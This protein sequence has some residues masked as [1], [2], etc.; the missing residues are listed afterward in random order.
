MHSNQAVSSVGDG[1]PEKSQTC[2]SHTHT[3]SKE[4]R[5][6]GL[7]HGLRGCRKKG[8]KSGGGKKRSCASWRPKGELHEIT[9]A[10]REATAQG[11]GTKSIQCGNVSHFLGH[12]CRGPAWRASLPPGAATTPGHS[13]C[14]KPLGQRVV[15]RQHIPRDVILPPEEPGS[16]LWNVGLQGRDEC[17]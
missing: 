8:S 13:C 4:S 9:M 1:G 3:I 2:T 14:D 5:P 12:S 16:K 6:G 11:A 17:V 15:S 7:R 10:G